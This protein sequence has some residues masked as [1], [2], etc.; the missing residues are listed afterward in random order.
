MAAKLQC[1]ICGG[2]LIG[3]PGGIFECENCGTEYSTEWAKAKIQEIT[4]T[5]KVEGTVE[6]TGKVQVEGPIKVEGN[7]N[8]D[9]L[10]QRGGFA[11]EDCEWSRAKELFYQVLN[12]EPQNADAYL[13]LAMAEGLC[14][15]KEHFEKLYVVAD[16]P[17]R[18]N[19]SGNLGRARQFSPSIAAWLDN[20]DN[21]G[22][23]ADLTAR[24]IQIEHEEKLSEIRKKVNTR[25]KKMLA[26][27]HF[28]TLG[29]TTDGAILT[30]GTNLSKQ[31]DVSTWKDVIAIMARGDYSLGLKTDGTVVSVGQNA[32]GECEVSD[33][34]HIVEAAAGSLHSVG[35]KD[36]GTVI[37]TKFRGG[38]FLRE[39]D[40]GQC[41]TSGWRDIISVAAG[42]WHTVGLK[43]D[44]TVVAVG[45]NKHGECNVS[46]WENIV[47]ISAGSAHT[48]G[49]KS[50]GTV[51][52]TEFIQVPGDG[53]SGE[54]EVSDWKDIVSIAAGS[55]HTVGLKADGTVVA[56]GDN[57]FGQCNVSD[58]R[59]IVDIVP[60]DCRTLALKADGTIVAVGANHFGEC[61]VAGWKLFDNYLTIDAEREAAK[62][63]SAAARIAK[64][65]ALTA[66]KA[67][68]EAEL[69]TIKGLFSGGKRREIESRLAEIEAELK[70]LG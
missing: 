37:S 30:A 41:D 66:E 4:G 34:S 17:L 51:V 5:V 38:Q 69:P 13:G 35:L 2:K 21:D 23:K 45:Y 54:C 7:A 43:S 42:D 19:A 68:L 57:R 48:V 10:L 70:R 36:D 18:L 67:Q 32:C 14:K 8:K 3:K 62:E 16:S 28:H 46:N 63:R 59:N 25:G 6:V 58:L 64:I 47:A 22:A 53:Y 40:F 39:F 44:G 27:G 33:W 49:L 60:G 1:E 12:I 61:N 50:D 31:C 11:L 52:A 9:T 56:I 15:D 26:T 20:L 24:Q 55:H 29:L 65:T